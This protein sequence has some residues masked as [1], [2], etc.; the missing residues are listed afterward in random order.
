MHCLTLSKLGQIMH[1]LK[2]SSLHYLK[3]TKCFFWKVN[4]NRNFRKKNN[5]CIT[6]KS[7]NSIIKN[8]IQNMNKRINKWLH[9]LCWSGRKIIGHYILQETSILRIKMYFSEELM[10]L[11]KSRALNKC[12]NPFFSKLKKKHSLLLLSIP[13]L[14]IFKAVCPAQWNLHYSE[15]IALLWYVIHLFNPD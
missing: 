5:I 7:N 9:S 13:I 3:K 11:D 12:K 8:F 14:T 4:E 15:H 1:C 2:R 6:N 10:F